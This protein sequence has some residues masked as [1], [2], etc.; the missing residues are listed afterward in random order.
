MS[1][2][3][4]GLQQPLQGVLRLSG[5]PRPPA[6]AGSSSPP[7]WA[8]PRERSPLGARRRTR[9]RTST[10]PSPRAPGDPATRSAGPRRAGTLLGALLLTTRAPLSSL[11]MSSVFGKPRAGSG[12]QSAPLEVNLAILGR[13]GAGKSGELG[14]GGGERKGFGWGR[15]GL[16]CRQARSLALGASC[17]QGVWVRQRDFLLCLSFF[18]AWCSLYFVLSSSTSHLCSVPRLLSFSACDTRYLSPLC[19]SLCLLVL[20]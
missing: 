5:R 7:G 13:R 19:L 2:P 11:T 1:R 17:T 10:G 20:R 16:A 3:R 6:F 14:G 9:A 4:G 18:V 8:R 12:P 15:C